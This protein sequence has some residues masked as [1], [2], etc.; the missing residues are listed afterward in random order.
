LLWQSNLKMEIRIA[1]F[2]K[3]INLKIRK[4]KFEILNIHIN[5]Y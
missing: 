5:I 4:N 3:K 2:N 1:S